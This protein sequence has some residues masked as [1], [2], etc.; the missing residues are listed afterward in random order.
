[1]KQINMHAAKTNLSALV[2]EAAAGAPFIIAISGKPMV[3]VV[4]YADYPEE[5]PCRVGFMKGRIRVPEGFDTMFA[6]E[7]EQMFYG[8]SDDMSDSAVDGAAGSATNAKAFRAANAKAVST[9]DA[10]ATTA[11]DAKATRAARD[12]KDPDGKAPR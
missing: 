1:V 9:E 7:I 5:T 4:P 3:K 11:A 6:K 8:A 10:K 12:E 2:K